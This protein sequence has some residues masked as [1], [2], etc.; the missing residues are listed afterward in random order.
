MEDL[1][2]LREA[3]FLSCPVMGQPYLPS[4]VLWCLSPCSDLSPHLMERAVVRCASGS[5]KIGFDFVCWLL[6][7]GC[8]YYLICYGQFNISSMK[9]ETSFCNMAW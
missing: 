4:K 3:L 2:H 1:L 6:I 7:F 9:E 8:V 5:E